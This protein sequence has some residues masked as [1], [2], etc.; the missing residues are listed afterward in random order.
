ME[1]GRL[2]PTFFAHV[3][4]NLDGLQVEQG[5]LRA[6][7]ED[8]RRVLKGTSG[9]YDAIDPKNFDLFV[10]LGL[11][12]DYPFDCLR[13]QFYSKAV[14]EQTV[15]DQ[16][17]RSL[18][19]STLSKLRR[20]TRRPAWLLHTPLLAPTD[21]IQVPEILSYA[22]FLS[23]AEDVFRPLDASLLW[24]P[25]QT[26][27][28]DHFSV[29]E[30]SRSPVR[31]RHKDGHPL[32]VEKDDCHKNEAFGKAIVEELKSRL[33]RFQP[34]EATDFEDSKLENSEPATWKPHRRGV[35]RERT[36]DQVLIQLDAATGVQLN[37]TAALIWERCDGSRTEADLRAELGE[38]FQTSE[39]NLQNDLRKALDHLLAVGA[40]ALQ[41]GGAAIPTDGQQPQVSPNPNPIPG[42]NASLRLRLGLVSE[43]TE[44]FLNQVKL[45][46]F[47]LRQ[48]GGA[49]K[50][51]PV[52][53]ITN[54]D[55][56]DATQQDFFTKHFAPIEFKTSPRLGAIPHTSKLNVFYA[57]DPSTYDVL[58]YMD[59][60][61]V[62]R[63]ALDGIADPILQGSAQFVC[64]RGG[65]TDRNMF[66]DFNGLVNQYCRHAIKTRIQHE[67]QEEWPMFNSGVF[68]ASSEAVQKV[69]RCA[70]EFTY[71]IF[72]DWQRADVLQKLPEEIRKSLKPNPPVRQNWTIEQGALAL[73]CINAGVSVHYLDESYNSWGGEEDFHVLHC[74]KSLYTFDRSSMFTASAE[75]WL[76]EYSASDVPGK[77]FLASTVRKYRQEFAP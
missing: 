34:N 13:Q 68:L 27:V 29:P 4:E 66:V 7:N 41:S 60:D 22:R 10:L 43:T 32:V 35:I 21:P 2:Q 25:A 38:R 67:G 31:L 76:E 28:N 45:C 19:F 57:I 8:L 62:V 26:R 69:R 24:Q 16:L 77:V 36:G 55:P 37:V 54:S 48:N 12:F 65:E 11:G 59:C 49:L 61:T 71:R 46:L 70:V 74:F 73:A 33:T 63:Q 23:L 14:T 44:A 40:I 64:R 20:V 58:L 17:M 1:L 50:D 5:Q 9:G 56:L 3:L 72:N 6:D 53:L 47:S 15:R 51:I 30:Y 39:K 75:M 42:K 18:A 52:T